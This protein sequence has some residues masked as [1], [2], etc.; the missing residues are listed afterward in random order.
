MNTLLLSQLLPFDDIK[1]NTMSTEMSEEKTFNVISKQVFKI[2]YLIFKYNHVN[3]FCFR[4]IN[5]N[6]LAVIEDLV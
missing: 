4:I 2:K 1:T 3:L 5:Q 6:Q